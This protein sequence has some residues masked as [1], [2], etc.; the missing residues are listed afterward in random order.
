MYFLLPSFVY[1]ELQPRQSLIPG[2]APVSKVNAYE[3]WPLRSAGNTGL[4]ILLESAL[5]KNAPATPLESA[6]PRNG[7]GGRGHALQSVP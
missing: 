1:I 3:G 2:L 7:G 4:I 6:L 5:T